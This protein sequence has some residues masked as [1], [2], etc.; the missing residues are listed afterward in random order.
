MALA[1]ITIRL[2]FS[3]IN[4]ILTT[5]SEVILMCRLVVDDCHHVRGHVTIVQT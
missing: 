2:G 3:L 4:F 1:T 5:I